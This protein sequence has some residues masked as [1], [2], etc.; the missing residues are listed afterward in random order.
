MWRST[1]SQKGQRLF[2][3]PFYC[4]WIC[5]EEKVGIHMEKEMHLSFKKNGEEER[6]LA[7]EAGDIII[8]D[9]VDNPFINVTVDAGW[10]KRSNS[11]APVA[12]I[13]GSRTKKILWMDPRIKT[14]VICDRISNH[15]ASPSD[16]HCYKNRNDSSQAMEADI[17][18]D[19]FRRSLM[20]HGLIYRYMKIDCVNHA[21]RGL[22]SKLYNI[23]NCT[24]YLKQ[25]RDMVKAVINRFG[26]DVKS[27]ISYNCQNRSSASNPTI[28]MTLAQDIINIPAHVLGHHRGSYAR[29]TFSATLA[30]DYG[31]FWL[32]QVFTKSKNKLWVEESQRMLKTRV[33][34]ERHRNTERHGPFNF[35]KT[36]KKAK[37]KYGP[38]AFQGKMNDEELAPAINILIQSLNKPDDERAD[39][40]RA[41]NCT[42]NVS[43]LKSILYPTDISTN[44]NIRY[45]INL[46]PEAKRMYT[47]LIG[48]DVE[49]CGLFVSSENGILA[50]SPDGKIGQDGILE[51]KGIIY[52]P[53]Q[54][55]Q[56]ADKFLIYK[57]PNDPKEG[58]LLK[59]THKYYYQFLMQ[60]HVNGKR[61]SDLFVYHKPIKKEYTKVE[62]RRN[63]TR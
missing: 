34:T 7:V 9:G 25:H 42:S 30:Y 15:E 56:R 18:V 38:N 60:L 13:I 55:P 1:E 62:L 61:F 32:P 45:G 48:V 52:P 19:G 53:E 50:A 35:S 2:P 27:A 63:R 40:E 58:L 20:D 17:I 51:I 49:E 6:R 3:Q 46:E 4:R 29:R 37:L 21:V 43:I 23:I 14:C 41:T 11:N 39:L 59:R 12:V 31:P 16:H 28:Q 5:V 33:R 22:N 10:A 26:K 36:T 8:I 47:F 57:N 54:V 44:E 24:S